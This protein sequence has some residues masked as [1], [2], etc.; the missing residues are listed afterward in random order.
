MSGLWASGNG[1][2]TQSRVMAELDRHRDTDIPVRALVIEAWS[3]ESTCTAFR[4]A[5]YE[6]HEDGAP[7]RLADVTLFSCFVPIMQYHS[8][9]SHHRTPLRDRTP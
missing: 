2:N 7:H 1:W 3:D 9:Y 6:V 8:E 4:D 5:R